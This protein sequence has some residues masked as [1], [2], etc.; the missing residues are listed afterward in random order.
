MGSRTDP[1]PGPIMAKSK[2][3]TPKKATAP[4]SLPKSLRKGA[5]PHAIEDVWAAGVGALAE[6]R[7]KGGDSFD[8]L[9]ALG[10]SVLEKG[11]DAARAASDQVGTAASRLTDTAKDVAEGAVDGVQDRVESVVEAVLARIGVPG[12]DEVLALR[13]QVEALQAKIVALGG[14]VDAPAEAAGLAD[15]TTTLYEVRPHE[16]GWAVQKAGA[17]RATAVHGTKKEALRDA[18]QTAKAQAPAQ[19]TVFKADGTVGETVE[20]EA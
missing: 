20:Y 1:T 14:S 12:R 10:N 3:S 4:A 16:R 8:S 2:T 6:A 15:A 17:A 11:S 18:R 13:E 7:K 19:L 5:L 9:V